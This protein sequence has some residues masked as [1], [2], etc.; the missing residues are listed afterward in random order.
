LERA[1]GEVVEELA[2][3]VE[4]SELLW[5]EYSGLGRLVDVEEVV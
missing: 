1:V 4:D 5:E 3:F 2:T